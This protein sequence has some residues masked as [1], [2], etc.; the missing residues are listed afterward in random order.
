MGAGD[1]TGVNPSASGPGAASLSSSEQAP[2][3]PPG[4]AP[5]AGEQRVHLYEVAANQRERVLS[6]FDT[7]RAAILKAVADQRTAAMAPILAVQ[8]RLAGKAG[9]SGPAPGASPGDGATQAGVGTAARL[10]ANVHRPH[11][12]A[13][14]IVGTIKLMVAEEVRVQL[15]AVLRALQARD[16]EGATDDSSVGPGTNAG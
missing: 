12:V 7:Q 15:Q 5:A 8:A 4:A 1:T 6:S 16:S 2:Q 11:A 3:T 9:A 13:A 10:Q 14:E